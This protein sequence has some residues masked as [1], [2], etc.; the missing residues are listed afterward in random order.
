MKCE[1]D[2]VWRWIDEALLFLAQRVCMMLLE[3]CISTFISD[4]S[5]A[6]PVVN[7][8]SL[9]PKMTRQS[10]LGALLMQGSHINLLGW[11]L[12]I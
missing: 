3:Q 5:W 10:G 6:A 8:R 9:S 12:L 7:H 4:C 11:Q 2:A 1:D